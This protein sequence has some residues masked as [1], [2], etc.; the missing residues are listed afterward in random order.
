MVIHTMLACKPHWFSIPQEVRS[1]LWVA[2]RSKDHER[3]DQAMLDCVS[4]LS[5][6]LVAAPVMTTQHYAA[7]VPRIGSPHELREEPATE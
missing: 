5:S 1:R 7:S 4:F 6:E 3:H 2:W